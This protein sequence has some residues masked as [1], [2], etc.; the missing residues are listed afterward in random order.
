MTPEM[1][2]ELQKAIDQQE[3]TPPRV[4]DPR[5]KKAYVLVAAEQY[6]RERCI[7]GVLRGD[8]TR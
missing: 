6:E 3:A 4:A 7:H 5:T 1:N 2:E 8:R